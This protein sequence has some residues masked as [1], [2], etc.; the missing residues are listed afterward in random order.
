MQINQKISHYKILQ[1]IG[2]GG[3]GIVYKAEDMR[4]KRTVAIKVLRPE[5]LGDPD[6]KER[7]LREARTASLLNHTNI[8]TIYD[9]DEWQ[10]QGYIVMEFVEGQTIKEIVKNDKFKI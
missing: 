1:K 3:M 9:I 5:I 7:F 10:G 8:T 2:E 4:L 6:A